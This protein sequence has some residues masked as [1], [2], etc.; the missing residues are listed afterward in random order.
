MTLVLSSLAN[1][2]KIVLYPDGRNIKG[3]LETI[4]RTKATVMPTVPKLL[5]MMNEFPERGNYDTSSLK[6]IMAGSEA[7][8]ATVRQ[9]FPHEI[10][11]GY[12]QTEMSPVICCNLQ[13]EFNE[14]GTLGIV[15]PRTEA[16]VVE[17]GNP[18]KILTIG[19]VGELLVRG[20]QRTQGYHNKPSDTEAV[21]MPDGWLRTGDLVKMNDKLRPIF[22]DRAKR[23]LKI[24]GHDI[25]PLLLEQA[26]GKHETVAEAVAIGLKDERSGDAAKLI[27]RLHEGATLTEQD[28]RKFLDEQGL[29]TLEKPKYIEF[30]DTPLLRNGKQ[31]IDWYKI[32]LAERAKQMAAKNGNQPKP[33]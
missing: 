4:Q 2:E 18:D 7:L 20:P 32:Q 21:I 6:T 17:F 27:V 5:Q 3:S 28:L 15:M 14:I 19:E 23:M 24:N 1:G 13:G 33:N 26:V 29:S 12:G 8:P 31:I 30:T 25:S 11:E 16:K 9:K 10:V 22:I